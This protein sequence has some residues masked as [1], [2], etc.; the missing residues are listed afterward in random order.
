MGVFLCDDRDLKI[1]EKVLSVNHCYGKGAIWDNWGDSLML[2]QVDNTNSI[3]A[4]TDDYE[5]YLFLYP[6]GAQMKYN[7]IYYTR[8]VTPSILT[9]NK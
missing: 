2:Y 3:F 4:K 8:K 6:H 9:G 1:A 7:G 5:N